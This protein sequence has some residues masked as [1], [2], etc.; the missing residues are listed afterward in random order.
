VAG[1]VT[2]G[3]SLYGTTLFT[4][5]GN[6][7]Y[8]YELRP[9]A[10]GSN[11]W[12]GRT[13]YAFEGTVDF[14]S[15]CNSAAPLTAGAGGVLYGTTLWGGTRSCPCGAQGCGTV[16]Q[17]TPP[18]TIGE[19][20]TETVIYTFTGIDGDGVYPA[21]GVVLGKNGVLYGTTAFGGSA[22]SGSPCST[23]ASG[24][25]TVFQLTPPAMPGSAWTETILHSFTG[26]NGEG[27]IPGPLTLDG[28]GVLSGPT[29]SGGTAGAGTIFAL[30]P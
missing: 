16:F 28:D 24:C 25:G 20:W 15:D 12:T 1:V 7:G 27:S 14:T 29:W 6:C 8:V 13:I 10:A 26:L 22:T 30:K 18:T 2:V 5:I 9:P 19:A 11:A 3:G 4:E 17:L 21:T 23:Y